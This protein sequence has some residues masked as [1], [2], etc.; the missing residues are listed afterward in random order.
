MSLL[1]ESNT[2]RNFGKRKTGKTGEIL[3][4]SSSVTEYFT[5]A[6]QYDYNFEYDI[7]LNRDDGIQISLNECLLL[8]DVPDV[9]WYYFDFYSLFA[10]SP[11]HQK[12]PQCGMIQSS[13]QFLFNT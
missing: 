2:D 4:T 1:S 6:Y 9:A 12:A 8:A 13:L 10:D 3:L 7:S 11:L 5:Q